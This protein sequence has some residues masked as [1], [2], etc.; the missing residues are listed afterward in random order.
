MKQYVID[1]LRLED[2]EGLKAYLDERFDGSGIGGLYW[3]PLDE[4]IYSDIQKAHVDCRPFYV[5]VELTEDRLS[6]EL[7]V[8]TTRKMRCDCI[9]YADAVQRNWIIDVVDAMLEQLGIS[10]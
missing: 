2:Y 6:C 9:A 4:S 3:I 5:A 1:Q 7:L 8:R 10:I